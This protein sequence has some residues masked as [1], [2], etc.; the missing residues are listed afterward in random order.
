LNPLTR[1]VF[2]DVDFT[3]IHPGPIFRA[4]GYERF[5]AKHGMRVEA[6]VFEEAVVR[7]SSVLDEAQE[8]IYDSRLF[9]EYSRTIIEHMGGA[10]PGLEACAR[11]IYEE[12]GA[13]HHFTL[14][15]DV[16]AALRELAAMGLRIGLISNTH[17]SLAA[18]QRHFDLDG[19]ISAALSSSEHGYMKPHPSIFR[20]ALELIGVEPHE[21]LMV[22][23]SLKQDILGAQRAGMRGVLLKRSAPAG[24]PCSVDGVP[25]IRTL[26]EVPL[27]L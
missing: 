18:F 4:E 5:C 12:W 11:E 16:P 27:H 19:L 21:A 22:G 26:A 7:A 20:A 1:A 15:E 17:R 9:V 14:Y 2:F 23:D 8:H 13:C 3:L 10:G 25:V 24:H 6:A